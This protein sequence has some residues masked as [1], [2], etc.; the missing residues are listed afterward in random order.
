MMNGSQI[1]KGKQIRNPLNLNE[2]SKQG[3]HRKQIPTYHMIPSIMKSNCDKGYECKT[4]NQNPLVM[5]EAKI[6]IKS[7]QSSIRIKFQGR[8]FF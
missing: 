4:R 8:N 5:I 1:E 2:W 3:T 6:S 7:L